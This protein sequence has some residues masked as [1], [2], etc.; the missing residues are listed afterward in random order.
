MRHTYDSSHQVI[1]HNPLCLD[2]HAQYSFSKAHQV[3]VVF[4]WEF[5]TIDNDW[6]ILPL[7]TLPDH[8]VWLHSLHCS[9]EH[10]ACP[11]VHWHFA[12]RRF[13]PTHEGQKRLRPKQGKNTCHGQFTGSDHKLPEG[14]KTSVYSTSIIIFKKNTY[15]VYLNGVLLKS[16]YQVGNATFFQRHWKK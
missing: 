12:Q 13:P 11:W 15:T 1:P 16:E 7:Y 9:C 4:E 8:S 6:V 10:F 5:L 2:S 3:K 14:W